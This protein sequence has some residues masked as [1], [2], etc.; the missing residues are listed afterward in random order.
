MP[1][2]TDPSSHSSSNDF[3][4][5][6]KLQTMVSNRRMRN[7]KKD[8]ED[9]ETL[10]D[11][12]TEHNQKLFI[13]SE[14]LQEENELEE[15]EKQI[16]QFNA[17]MR[18]QGVCDEDV[19][20]DEIELQIN[21]FNQNIQKKAKLDEP[22]K[23]ERRGP[24]KEEKRAIR[25]PV[26]EEGKALHE[27]N[28]EGKPKRT[29][30]PRMNIREQLKRNYEEEQ[31][32][33]KS[34]SFEVKD[35]ENYKNISPVFLKESTKPLIK[36]KSTFC[37][38]PSTASIVKSRSPVKKPLARKILSKNNDDCKLDDIKILLMRHNSSIIKPRKT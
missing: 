36:G 21:R 13:N 28:K 31:Q 30:I 12:L 10:R 5:F 27:P 38:A 17:V 4:H 3:A 8:E 18:D 7:M 29:D 26:K 9:L 20:L 16:T 1:Q 24:M 32:K 19:E 2:E 11:Q 6:K 23:E 25:E 15:L 14:S 37:P 34:I 33:T 35:K 22:M